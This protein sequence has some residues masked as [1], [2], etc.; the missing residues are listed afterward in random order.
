MI[1]CTNNKSWLRGLIVPVFF[2]AFYS[3]CSSGEP[4][5]Q[6]A[7]I[8]RKQTLEDF[9]HLTSKLVPALNSDS[10][11][12]EAGAV[13]KDFLLDLHG[14][15]RV[16]LGVG[17]LNTS[18][19]YLTGYSLEDKATGKLLKNEYKGMKFA[20]FEGVEKIVESG[21]IVQAPLYFRDTRVLVIGF[22]LVKGDN[23]LGIVYFSFNSDE[24]VK[25]WGISEQEFLRIDFS[26]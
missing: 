8:F 23:L 9:N 24:F 11:V 6:N 19:S 20:S 10:P 2:L 14:A 7:Q 1:L 16:I 25:G 3:A 22:P 21:K 13:L 12:I 17:M 26:K 4:L 18:G 5:S 15:G